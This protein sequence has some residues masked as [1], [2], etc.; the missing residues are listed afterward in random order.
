MY[1]RL[2]PL[3]IARKLCWPALLSSDLQTHNQK[4][5][6]CPLSQ[7]QRKQRRLLQSHHGT[8]Q[9]TTQNTMAQCMLLLLQS[10][11]VTPLHV[12]CTPAR[13]SV[14]PVGQE[15][16][17]GCCAPTLKTCT[18]VGPL[19]GTCCCRNMLSQSANKHD[20]SKMH[21]TER[22]SVRCTAACCKYARA[23]NDTALAPCWQDKSMLTGFRQHTHITTCLGPQVVHRTNNTSHSLFKFPVSR[24]CDT[25]ST[26]LQYHSTCIASGRQ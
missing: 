15:A 10:T 25:S 6:S 8:V 4:P 20:A 11:S 9:H 18:K 22:E 26:A 21:K 24:P 5:Y 12:A 14:G 16:S 13:P 2:L 3:M 17:L 19:T 23:C 7:Q 1:L